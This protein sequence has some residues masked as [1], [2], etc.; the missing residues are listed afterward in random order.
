M[1]PTQ[2]ARLTVFLVLAWACSS[3]AQF[4]KEY[5]PWPVVKAG[6]TLKLPFLGGINSPKPSV[7]DFDHDGLPDLFLGEANGKLVYF[8]NSGTAAQP[9]WTP[10]T[11]RFGGVNIRSWHRFADIDADGDWDLF[12]DAGNLMT[13]FYRNESAGSNIQF[14]LIKDDFGQ[15]ETGVNTTGDFVDLDHDGDLDFFLGSV[16]G[17]LWYYRNDGDSTSPLPF[18][19]LV[20]TFYDSV[21]AFPGGKAAS[22]ENPQHGF[23]TI[24]FADFDGDGDADLF[25]GDINNNSAYLFKN[26]GT[27]SVSHL[28]K[29]SET[30]LPISTLGLNHTAFADLD[31]DGDLDL[32]VGAA[33]GDDI[34]DLFLLRNNGTPTAP[35]YVV[36]NSNVIKDIDVGSYAMPTL[37]DLDGDGDLDILIGRSDGRITYYENV[38]TKTSPSFVWDSD[39][40]KNIDV[41]LSAAPTLVD[42]DRDGDLDLL[43]G[44]EDGKIQYWRNDGS[45]SNFNPVLANSQLGGIQ[46]DILATPCP[47][48]LNND[49]LTDLVVGEWDFNGFAN[50]LLFQNQ[51][52][53]NNPVLTPVTT[54]LLKHQLRDMTIPVACDWDCDGRKDLIVGGRLLGLTLYKNTAPIGSFPDSLELLPQSDSIPGSDDGYRLSLAMADIDGDLDRDVFVGEED[55]GVNFYRNGGTACHC[56]LHGDPN[57][58]GETDILDVV[59]TINIAFRGALDPSDGCCPYVSRVDHNCDCQVDVLDV[60]WIVNA[61]FRGGPPPCN[62]CTTGNHCPR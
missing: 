24:S 54:R 6:D 22:V 36:E 48:D 52:P 21:F 32:I 53:G 56:P 40:Y 25:W 2:I 41:G 30:F 31:G 37:G 14:T 34:N 23:S 7:V 49:G 62:T 44:N 45:M 57:G 3:F 5:D 27:P 28:K 51:G 55:G 12:C 9:V 59:T 47:V 43:I 16:T 26:L 61:A 15:F 17:D 38:G 18:Y 11:E 13:A 19:T 10:V 39:A 29:Q 42:W 58:D 33:N 1:G 50:L 8:H 20:S 60:V 46:V 4:S 35:N